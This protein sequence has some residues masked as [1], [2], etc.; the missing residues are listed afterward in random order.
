MDD[1]YFKFAWL[2]CP[3]SNVLFEEVC[4]VALLGEQYYCI[5]EVKVPSGPRGWRIL[6]ND[7]MKQ[8]LEK[9]KISVEEL[10]GKV[11]IRY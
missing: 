10:G 7:R 9:F 5:I 4:G 11:Y 2:K 3:H 1:S 8:V 6:V